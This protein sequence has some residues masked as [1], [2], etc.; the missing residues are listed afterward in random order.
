[1]LWGGQYI[2]DLSFENQRVAEFAR[3]APSAPK[4]DVQFHV[5]HKDV[6]EGQHE[7][8]LKITA[9]LK[10]EK[11]SIYLME[12]VYSGLFLVRGFDA[13]TQEKLLLIECP[14]LLFPSARAILITLTQDSGFPPMYLAPAV[15]FAALYQ[16]KKAAPANT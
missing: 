15:D 13:D 10:E 14:R 4:T 2:K 9:S 5:A 12:L 1:M 16:Q 7:V 11:G 3:K 6:G 8:S